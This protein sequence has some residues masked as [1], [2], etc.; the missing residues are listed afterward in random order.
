[1]L[2]AAA[3]MM[4]ASVVL[5]VEAFRRLA[6]SRRGSRSVWSEKRCLRWTIG[7]LVWTISVGVFLAIKWSVISGLLRSGRDRE[8]E[9]GAAGG[10]GLGP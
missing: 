6:N 8:M 1:M 7:A 3:T 10:G 5:L 9:H 2:I 4:F